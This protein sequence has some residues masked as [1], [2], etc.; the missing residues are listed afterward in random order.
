M[1]IVTRQRW[2]RKKDAKNSQKPRPTVIHQKFSYECAYDCTNLAGY[3]HAV[4]NNADNPPLMLHA[5]SFAQTLT[6]AG[7]GRSIVLRHQSRVKRAATTYIVH[8]L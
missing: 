4:Q 2:L 7:D 8:V 3:A 5:I 6:I 1:P